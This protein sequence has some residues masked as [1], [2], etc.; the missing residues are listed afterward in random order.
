VLLLL[1]SNDERGQWEHREREEGLG[2]PG[3]AMVGEREKGR[4]GRKGGEW[5]T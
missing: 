5:K 4:E 2:V 3:E 1:L